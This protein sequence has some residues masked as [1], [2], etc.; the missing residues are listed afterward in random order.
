MIRR[1]VEPPFNFKDSMKKY[2]E[3]Y[4]KNQVLLNNSGFEPWSS[5]QKNMESSDCKVRESKTAFEGF[6]F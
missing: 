2:E 1:E 6:T 4:A 5:W 3:N